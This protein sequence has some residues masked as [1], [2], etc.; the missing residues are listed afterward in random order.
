VE[1]LRDSA[2]VAG[3]ARALRALVRSEGYVFFRGL[4]DRDRVLAAGHRGLACLQAAGWLQAGGPPEEAPISPPVR[5]SEMR[6]AWSDPGYRQW[7]SSPE[8]NRLP[9]EPALRGVML[10]LLGNTA[11][12]YPT[13][14]ARVVYPEAMVPVHGGRYVHQDIGVIGIQDM[15]TTWTPLMDIRRE[16][17]GLCVRPGSQAGPLVHPHVLK[18]DAPGWL[19]TDFRAGDVLA[20]QCLTAHAALPNGTDRLRLSAEFRWQLADDP[21]PR[22][23]VFGPANQRWELF[24][25]LFGRQRWWQPVPS[26]LIFVDRPPGTPLTDVAPSRY[27]DVHAQ[28]HGDVGRGGVR[29][30]AGLVP[31]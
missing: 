6:K 25:R 26:G 16:L 7:A 29:F 2:R 5:E 24:S 31:H 12:S 27:V 20:F 22:H 1:E 18:P 28:P 17:G 9:Y 8:L 21:V 13:K 4:L 14:V 10:T 23:L 11:F 15:F 3:D 30:R 19:T